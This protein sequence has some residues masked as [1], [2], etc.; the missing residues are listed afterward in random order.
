[1]KRIP[2]LYIL[3][4]SLFFAQT[5]LT[6]RMSFASTVSYFHNMPV[7]PQLQS[8]KKE[9]LQ[10]KKNIIL[11]LIDALRPDHLTPYG[12]QRNTTPNLHQFAQNSLVYTQFYA[13]APWTRPS[14]ASFLTGL[15]PGKHTVE[16]RTLALSH[17]YITLAEHLKKLGYKTGAVVA[18][19][20]ASSAAGLEQGFDFYSD[21]NNIKKSL[22]PAKDII[23]IAEK[24]L[25]SVK[26]SPFF[27]FLFLVDTHDPYHA[28][29]GFENYFL[30]DYKGTI[31]RTPHWEYNNHYPEPVREKMLSLYD[32]AI[33]YTDFEIGKFFQFLKEKNQF[34]NSHIFV[35]ADHGE[36]F[37]EHGK[38]LHSHHFYD[39]IIRI[40]LM[41]KFAE[42][43]K[44]SGTVHH[45]AD[46]IDIFPSLILLANDNTFTLQEY[47]RPLWCDIESMKIL[48]IPDVLKQCQMK[49]LVISE[50]H[51][52]GI[53]RQAIFNDQFK[54]IYQYPANEKEFLIHIPEKKLLPSVNFSSEVI[55]V[56]DRKN[57]VFEQN[58]LAEN[59]PMEAKK[60]L[61]ILT[62]YHQASKMR[63]AK[64]VADDISNEIQQNLR[65]L[66]Y[67]Q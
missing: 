32:D 7:K 66:G 38:Y 14:T 62:E 58:N 44:I 29:Q 57:D 49:K 63:P 35:S 43:I 61:K 12:Y 6:N 33:R 20:N 30:P 10:A 55:Q 5:Y 52:Y 18:N 17:E 50:Y 31:L 37:G 28:P 16:N 53:D 48:L 25:V 21:A 34:E 26:D 22:P 42:P 60:L 46:T 24:W 39:E 45:L 51:E 11:I 59:M 2:R 4:F 9:D 67:V 54:V 41:I 13:N 64:K 56:F 15:L 3:C 40:P 19:G 47:A 1:M 65:S 8:L 36:G 27:L 23:T